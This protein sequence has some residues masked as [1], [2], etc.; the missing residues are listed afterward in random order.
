M[1]LLFYDSDHCSDASRSRK[2]T[3]TVTF[4]QARSQMNKATVCFPIGDVVIR[5][6]VLAFVRY[7]FV[8]G[9]LLN[10]IEIQLHVYLTSINI[11][12]PLVG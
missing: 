6:F 3:C 9:C 8:P 12:Y 10:S 11:I 7:L 1:K 5:M 4:K 2:T